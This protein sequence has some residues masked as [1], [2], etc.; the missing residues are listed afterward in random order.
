MVGLYI[1]WYNVMRYNNTVVFKYLCLD[2]GVI[3]RPEILDVE[4]LGRLKDTVLMLAEKGFPSYETENW[5]EEYCKFFD[6]PN[7]ITAEGLR[8][9]PK[10]LQMVHQSLCWCL[11]IRK[12]HTEQQEKAYIN[13][14]LDT[15]SITKAWRV[16]RTCPTTR[17]ARWL[18]RRTFKALDLSAKGVVNYLRHGP[19][20][21]F[22]GEVGADKNVIYRSTKQ[23]EDY[24]CF[25][26][27]FANESLYV[28][29]VKGLFRFERTEDSLRRFPCDPGLTGNTHRDVV[30]AYE[31]RRAALKKCPLKFTVTIGDP[32]P[33][34]RFNESRLTL[35]PKS[36]KGPRGVF[37]SDKEA[38]KWQLAQG[39]AIVRHARSSWIGLCHNPKDQLPSGEDAYMGSYCRWL[40]T[41]DLSDASDRIPLSLVA[42]LFHRKDYLALASTRPCYV[43]LP[44][45]E[46]HRLGM[47]SPMGDGKTFPML[48]VICAILT[49]SA[50]LDAQGWMAARPPSMKRVGS[51]ARSIRIFGDDIIVPSQYFDAVVRCLETHN[52][53][54]NVRKSFVNGFFR[55]ACGVDAYRGTD[56]TPLRQKE[57]LDDADRLDPRDKGDAEKVVGLIALHNACVMR[58]FTKTAYAIRDYVSHAIPQYLKIGLTTDHRRNPT[59]WL[60]TAPAKGQCSNCRYSDESSLSRQARCVWCG[61][62]GL[63][64][65]LDSLRIRWKYDADRQRIV[66]HVLGP[67]PIEYHESLD[68]WYDLNHALFPKQQTETAFPSRVSPVGSPEASRLFGIACR[69][70]GIEPDRLS[71][72]GLRPQ[73]VSVE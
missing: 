28:D 3:Y 39:E 21:T 47:F 30:K 31:K 61:S 33:Q 7:R 62:G 58:G 26:L 45:G 10:V 35:V 73:W 27:F 42:Y 65:Y 68:R 55:E 23:L 71:E 51:V 40:S 48:T 12:P 4:E 69:R 52:L 24:A 18:C 37:I 50:I 70:A 38:M 11:K 8:D 16:D 43:W 66:Q 64:R 54:V 2:L 41:L 25:D 56:I 9:H 17:L 53:K 19:G 13:K 20:A 32:R 6:T 15:E 72:G 36:Y 34:K 5:I 1:Q 59:C 14:F 44:N 63:I 57:D 60:V 29:F 22:D 46:K 49:V 67:T